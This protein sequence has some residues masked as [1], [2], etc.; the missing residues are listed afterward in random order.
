MR[1]GWLIGLWVYALAANAAPRDLGKNYAASPELG[2]ELIGT[3]PEEWMLGEWINSPPLTLEELRGKVVLVRWW[4]A[5]GCPYCSA[6]ADALKGL[7]EGHRARGLV[8]VGAYHHKAGTP[9]TR[10]HVTA[11][12]KRLGFGFPVAG[13]RDWHTLERWWLEKVERGWTSVTFVIGRDGMIRHVHGGGAYFEGEPGFAEL[14][15][16]VVAALAE[17]PSR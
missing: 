4:T 3:R 15:G 8:V 9:L 16:A 7:W 13:D 10:E 5:P 14:R 6:S 2:Q 17:K 1:V 11:Q 12:A